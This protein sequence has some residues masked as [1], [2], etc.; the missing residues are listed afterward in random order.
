MTLGSITPFIISPVTVPII[1]IKNKKPKR[2]G[3]K[4]IAHKSIKI[5]IE[6]INARI[7]LIIVLT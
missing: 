5:T 6:I 7:F 4:K 3:I 1:P 2:I